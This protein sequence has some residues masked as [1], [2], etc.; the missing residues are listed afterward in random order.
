MSSKLGVVMALVLGFGCV[1]AAETGVT[2][3]EILIG[4]FAAQTGPAAQ[5]GTRMQL[6]ILAYFNAVNSESNRHHC[7]WAKGSIGPHHSKVEESVAGML[8]LLAMI[9]AAHRAAREPA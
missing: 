4:Q 7:Q 5:L 3:K 1:H 6:G 2:P 8:N 9:D